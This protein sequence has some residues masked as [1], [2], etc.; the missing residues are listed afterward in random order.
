MKLH[1]VNHSEPLLFSLIRRLAAAGE[2]IKFDAHSETFMTGTI[3]DLKPTRAHR[4]QYVRTHDLRQLEI[5]LTGKGQSLPGTSDSDYPDMKKLNNP[6]YRPSGESLLTLEKPVDDHYTI[7]K[8]DGMW[9][10]VDAYP[11][12]TGEQTAVKESTE[13]HD[14][15]MLRMLIKLLQRE[16]KIDDEDIALDTEI[17]MI[18]IF[19]DAKGISIQIGVSGDE[20]RF[21]ISIETRGQ[22]PMRRDFN[23]RSA[24][25]IVQMVRVAYDDE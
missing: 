18:G 25:K 15:F 7:K 16:L 8:I 3:Q 23:H 20:G 24:D 21:D 6:F 12:K 14:I 13:D 17:P 22:V 19:N 11:V 9:T 1:E 10:I 5:Y 4:T 2:T